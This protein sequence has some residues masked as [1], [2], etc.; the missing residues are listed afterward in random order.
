MRSDTIS[1]SS[2]GLGMGTALEQSEL[3][4]EY[5]HLSAKDT[6]R[7][8]LLAEEM[9]GMF[10]N[11]TGE[12]D[13]DFWIDDDGN[14]FRLHLAT[15]T[16]MNSEKRERLLSVSTSGENSAAKGFMGKIGDLFSRAMEPVGGEYP[17]LYL[18]GWYCDNDLGAFDP[19][20]AAVQMWSLNRY[21]ESLEQQEADKEEWDE[22]EKSIVAKLAD[23]V[24]IAIR[25]NQVE[26]IIYKHF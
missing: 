2:D 12:A 18:G 26:M 14:T 1:I 15:E 10:R 19:T 17:E 7:L 11:L 20:A 6:I 22:L 25:S 4:A 16:L 21:K 5:K 24:E 9:M 3:V 23:E 13:A 8:R